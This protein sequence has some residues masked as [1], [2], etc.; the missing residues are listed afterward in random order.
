VLTP[1][2][3]NLWA[4]RDLHRFSWLA[5]EFIGGIPHEWNW[6]EL[7]PKAVHF[8]LGTPDMPGHEGAAFA[9]EWWQYATE[10]SVHG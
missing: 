8:T 9:Q 1:E 6:L 7:A 2:V 5:D 3:V 10:E 4:G